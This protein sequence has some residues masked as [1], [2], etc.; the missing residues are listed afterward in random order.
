MIV[1]AVIDEHGAVQDPRIVHSTT[2]PLLNE[3]ALRAVR[4][5]SY[6]PATY[7]GKFVR[8]SVTVTVTFRLN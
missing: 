5:W 8:V 6:Q 3:E 1:E 2:I 4:Q 7:R